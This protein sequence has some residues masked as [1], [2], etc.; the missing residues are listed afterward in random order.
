MPPLTEA[1][2]L[3]ALGNA[4]EAAERH[5]S[6]RVVLGAAAA[7][8]AGHQQRPRI[9][10]ERHAALP[11]RALALRAG[12]RLQ[13]AVL[14]AGGGA[15]PP[16]VVE[17]DLGAGGEQPGRLREADLVT[18]RAG[19]EEAGAG[20]CPQALALADDRGSVG[21]V[22][23]AAEQAV[24]EGEARIERSDL[25]VG[26][27]LGRELVERVLELIDAVDVEQPQQ[28]GADAAHAGAEN[29]VE[30]FR[31]RLLV[32]VEADAVTPKSTAMPS[33]TS[34]GLGNVSVACS[35]GLAMRPSP[36]LVTP[37]GA[38]RMRVALRGGDR[39]A[40]QVDGDFAGEI[41]RAGDDDLVGGAA[42]A[43]DVDGENA[44]CRFA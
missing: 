4:G 16:H 36:L 21:A 23:L 13:R 39:D 29:L 27:E 9:V 30:V 6:P 20:P 3:V 32:G 34:L 33:T 41:G 15:E 1:Q 44:G 11:Q 35:A 10:F 12:R 26:V 2:V 24:G 31:D 43:V 14:V 42:R 7:H 40:G 25:G 37:P 19:I 8:R 38:C 22:D 5:N 17:G 18:R 28:H